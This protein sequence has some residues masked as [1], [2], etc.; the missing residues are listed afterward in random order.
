MVDSPNLFLQILPY[1][2]A[3]I[4]FFLFIVFGS[5]YV[6]KGKTKHPVIAAVIS[7][8]FCLIPPLALIYLSVLIFRKDLKAE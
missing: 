5:Y 4:A 3:V 8:L 7:G 6:A 2:I 1:M